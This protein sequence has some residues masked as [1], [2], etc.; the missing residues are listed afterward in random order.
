MEDEWNMLKTKLS[1]LHKDDNFNLIDIRNDYVNE[2]P[3]EIS[4]K[5]I[6]FPTIMATK[7]GNMLK[8]LMIEKKE[9]CMIFVKIF[10]RFKYEFGIIK[11]IYWW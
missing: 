10:I 6:G 11:F 8:V 5:I 2:L 1:N 4:S 9:K 3:S 7:N